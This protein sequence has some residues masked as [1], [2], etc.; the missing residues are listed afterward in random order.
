MT[1]AEAKAA[2]VAAAIKQIEEWQAEA[3]QQKDM[4]RMDCPH[5]G[6]RRCVSMNPEGYR[7]LVWLCP[8]CGLKWD[9]ES[10]CLRP[11]TVGDNFPGRAMQARVQ[12]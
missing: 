10:E 11:A 2:E 12:D 9:D 8:D 6:K 7:E 3:E 5:P 1:E 4:L